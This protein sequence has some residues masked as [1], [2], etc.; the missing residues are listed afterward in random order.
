[1][2]YIYFIIR[3]TIYIKQVLSSEKGTV[4]INRSQEKVL[5]ITWV[6][7]EILYLNTDRFQIIGY[8]PSVVKIQNTS[9]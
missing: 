6:P 1:M 5:M 8:S 4:M 7:L 2:Y 9:N 3:G